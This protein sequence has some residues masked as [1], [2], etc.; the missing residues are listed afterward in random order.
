MRR[1]AADAVRLLCS[2]VT[3]SMGVIPATPRP[4]VPTCRREGRG[5][6]KEGGRR[7]AGGR[8]G[9]EGGEKDGGR[10]GRRKEGEERCSYIVKRTE[11]EVG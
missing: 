11:R 4:S 6:E 8:G 3:V 5:G 1:M 2:L 9:Q 7:K 10:E